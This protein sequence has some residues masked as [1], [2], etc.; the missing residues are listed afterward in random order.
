MNYGH[1]LILPLESKLI[2]RVKHKVKNCSNKII[3]VIDGSL[4]KT[5][6]IFYFHVIFSVFVRFRVLKVYPDVTVLFF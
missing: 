3:V 1:Y 4:V 2:K 5:P 6:G